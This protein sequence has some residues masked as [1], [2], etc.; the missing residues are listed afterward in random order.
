VSIVELENDMVGE[1]VY[2]ILIVIITI[3]KE[4]IYKSYAL[5]AIEMS[6]ARWVCH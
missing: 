3:M 5:D 1:Y 4:L 2:I 6:M